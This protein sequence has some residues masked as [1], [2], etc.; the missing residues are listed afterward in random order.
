MGRE[1]QRRVWGEG[2]WARLPRRLNLRLLADL[3]VVRQLLELLFLPV[4]GC[5]KLWCCSSRFLCEGHDAVITP[6]VTFVLLSKIT[7]SAANRL[8]CAE[9]LLPGAG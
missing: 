8:R 6:C 2:W 5:V 3:R 9:G 1:Y 7:E 4:M